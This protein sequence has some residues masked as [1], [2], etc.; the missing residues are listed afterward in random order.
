MDAKVIVSAYEE[1]PPRRRRRLISRVAP[2]AAARQAG[3]GY[4]RR[5]L[6]LA[7]AQ[8]LRR[9]RRVGQQQQQQ[10]EQ[11]GPP[12]LEWGEWK[13]A[14]RVA[15]GDVAMMRNGRGSW[16][17]RLRSCARLWIRTFLRRARRIRENAS[18]KK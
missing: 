9:R 11:R 6:L 5:G 2:A 15:A 1:L 10:L 7:Y 3:G 4:S 17:S 8:Q 14:G 18:C 16:C 13:A 12:L